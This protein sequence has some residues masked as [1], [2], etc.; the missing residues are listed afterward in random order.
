MGRGRCSPGLGVRP[1]LVA[2]CRIVIWCFVG[3][4]LAVIDNE[5]ERKEKKIECVVGGGKIA[6]PST[7]A[8]K[9]RDKKPFL[10]PPAFLHQTTIFSLQLPNSGSAEEDVNSL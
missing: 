8:K 9:L 1:S 10:F 2:F 3:K 7:S 4:R 6:E 5:E